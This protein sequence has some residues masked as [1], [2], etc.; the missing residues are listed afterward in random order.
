[1]IKIGPQA[2]P[3][4]RFLA[5]PADIVF[6]G[7]A[8][9][10]GK[11][12]GLLLEPLRHIDNPS[13]GA[14]IFRRNANQITNEGGL[15][16]TSM[17]IY[18]Y[19]HGRPSLSPKPTWKFPSGAKVSFAHMQYDQDRLSWQGAQ[20]TMIGFDELTHFSRKQFFYMLSRNR[21]VCGIRPY[22]RATTNPD[23]ESWVAEFIG[24]WW[25]PQTGYAIPER[26]GVLRYMVQ[27]NDVIHWGDT[28]AEVVKKTGCNPE[29]CKSVTFIAS[30]VQD[31]KVLLENDPGYLANLKAMALIDRE[32][33]LL[34]NWK[35][36]PAAGL[37]FR[38][39][40]VPKDGWLD[41]IPDD[42]VRWV[43]CWD[44]AATDT[45]ENGDPAYTAGILI[46]KRRCGRYVVADV[47]RVRLSAGKVRDHILA[48]ARMDKTKYKHVKIRL[49]QDPGQAGK[50]QA[51]NFIKF[52]SGFSV[53]TERETGS[54]EARA[55]PFAAQWQHGNVD[56]VL[57]PWTEE[58]LNELES[59]PEGKFK[60]QVDASADGFNELERVQD[61][62]VP[63]KSDS[64]SKNSYWM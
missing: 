7:G 48:T 4:E 27:I 33:L 62:S 37:F 5:S 36:K 44:L 15:W 12:Y 39:S 46:G 41:A 49:P 24:W 26:S 51:E 8:A 63:G 2:G 20:I 10:G 14:V 22:V 57:G 9:G 32:R 17:T 29:D 60:D 56:V 59:F 25:N 38:R 42:V 11:S 31:N 55:E 3:Q 50:D 28:P 53:V 16:D 34:G 19:A 64:L 54:K 58:Y 6:Y 21:S 23:A 30:R 40:Q 43:R 61:I 1:V 47:T 45:D 52:L 18:P 35:I 13:F